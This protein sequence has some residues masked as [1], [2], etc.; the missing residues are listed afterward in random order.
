MKKRKREKRIKEKLGCEFIRINF[1]EKDYDE[2]HES[3][4]IINHI[5]KSKNK[6]TKMSFMDKI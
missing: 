4:D 2:Y 6:L 1:D 5:D 3:D